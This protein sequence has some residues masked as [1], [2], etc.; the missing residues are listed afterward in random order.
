MNE[1]DKN[2]NDMP[3]NSDQSDPQKSN[4][5]EWLPPSAFSEGMKNG[6]G[7]LPASQEPARVAD[8]C[9]LGTTEEQAKTAARPNT[10]TVKVLKRRGGNML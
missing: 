4:S 5:D 7:L 1:H 9:L 8:D 6:S 3:S 2:Y 10:K